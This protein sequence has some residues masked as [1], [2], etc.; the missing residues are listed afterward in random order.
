MTAKENLQRVLAFD[1]PAFVPMSVPVYMLHYNGAGH[2]ARD[3]SAGDGAPAG[4]RWT[5]I[6][7]VGWHKEL[8]DVMG[9][10][11]Y[12]PL[13]DLT[14][15]DDFSF[16]SAEDPAINAPL[17][18]DPLDFDREQLYLAGTH[19]DLLFE[20]A[21]KLV[22]M[23]QLFIAMHEQPAA[24][25]RLL[26]RITD[27][28]LGL[29]HLYLARGVE[30][31]LTGDDLGHQHGLLFSRNMLEEFFL[32]E[33]RRLF[34]LYRDHGIRIN[35][36]SCGQIQDMLDIFIDLGIDILNP[37]QASANDLALVRTRTQGH[38]T[39]QGAIPSHLIT[40]GPIERIRS[41]VRDTIHLLGCAGG[42]ICT[43]DQFLPAPP[44]HL[45]AFAEAVQEFGRYPLA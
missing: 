30:W 43:A 22:G 37:I 42:Y 1:H 13:A 45:Q 36:H 8:P 6:W 35:F 10:V 19:R 11:E 24:V 18:A 3:G 27:F 20:A 21:Y 14:R 16:P 12:S 7:G 44:A 9:M 25:K 29:A 23:Q 31:I 33:Y 26:Q 39:L 4:A 40:E 38:L 15:V 41:E 17:L 32:P 28:H 5:D 34:S 2:E